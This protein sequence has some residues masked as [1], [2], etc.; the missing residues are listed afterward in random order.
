VSSQARL[1]LPWQPEPAWDEEEPAPSS[2]E[3]EVLVPGV[4]LRSALVGGLTGALGGVIALTTAATFV[5]RA[6][7]VELAAL[8]VGQASSAAGMAAMTPELVWRRMG[9]A[10]AAGMLVG[11]LLG[12]LTRR[13]H[14]RF[15]RALFGVLFVPSLWIFLHAFVL[16]RFA[17]QVAAAAPFVPGLLGALAFGAWLGVTRPAAPVRR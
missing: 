6:R 10:A 17:P 5:L 7:V 3:R 11:A 8:A 16:D 15:A 9:L 12:W 13:L 1:I 14:G 4:P 2:T